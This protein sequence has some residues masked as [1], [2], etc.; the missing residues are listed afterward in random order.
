[1]ASASGRCAVQSWDESSESVAPDGS[2]RA[3]AR[4]VQ[5]FHG[6]VEGK[7]AASW[8]MWYRPDGSSRFVG[9]QEVEG[10]LNGRSGRFVLETH[11]DFDGTVAAWDASVVQG[12]GSGDLAGLCG[13]ARFSATHDGRADFHLDYTIND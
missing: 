2:K 13:T 4:V 8:L 1:M 10:T 6:D 5:V 7:G 9:F 12:S 11:G 3:T